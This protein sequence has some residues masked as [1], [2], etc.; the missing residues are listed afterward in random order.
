MKALP[1]HCVSITGHYG[2]LWK[3]Y[4]ALWSVTECYEALRNVTGN[5]M[6]PLQK[7]WILPI[8]S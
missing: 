1:K 5:I 7:I 6:E 8:S 2:T 3:H 4:G